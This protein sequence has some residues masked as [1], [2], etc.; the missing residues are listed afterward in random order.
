MEWNAMEVKQT[1]RVSKRNTQNGFNIIEI[2]IAVA[3]SSVLTTAVYQTF[4]S[5]QRSYLMQSGTAAMQQTLRG[6]MYL[7]T[8]DLLSSGYNPTKTM[9]NYV[10]FVTGFPAP[11]NQFV[12]NYAT[13]TS[14][15]A[16]TLDANVNGAIDPSSNEQ[17]AYRF[18]NA[19]KTLER[20]NATKINPA[21]KWEAVATN[22]DAVYFAYFDQNNTL[23]T[24]PS[25]FRYIE[26][27]LLVRMAQQDNKYTNT[28]VYK[29]KHGDKLCPIT[30]CP[31]GYFGDHYH[32][33]L[34]TT[35]IQLRNRG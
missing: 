18:N 13:D 23:T 21:D 28:T 20:F 8:R 15:V 3:I 35:T 19:T 27:S 16:F 17:I 2:M 26:A 1:V 10:S 25:D 24:N 6:G 12:V 7:M 33:S 31:N 4:H 9:S 5:Q 32:R 30:T 14:I 34:L 29:N 11:N 22:I